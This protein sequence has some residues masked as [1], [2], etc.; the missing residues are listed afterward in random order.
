MKIA[1]I[2]ATGT[3]GQ[4][5]LQEALSRGHDVTAIARRTNALTPSDHVKVVGGDVLDVAAMAA[6]VRG[7]DAV[8]DAVAPPLD[9][10][11]F[12]A[13]APMA[14]IEALKQA[15][16]SRFDR[17]RRRGQ[18]GGRTRF[19]AVRYAGFPGSVASFGAGTRRGVGR[20]ARR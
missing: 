17:G 14:L 9:D 6:A 1:L 20:T 8:I 19:A 7:H 13:R 10:P 18:S 2:G 3:I 4:R 16:V 15:G 5:I 11:N 12:L